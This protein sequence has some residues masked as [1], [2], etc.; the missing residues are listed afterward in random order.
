MA[1]TLERHV[2]HVG[3][4][5]GMQNHDH[6][7]IH[8]LSKS[9]DLLWRCDQYIANAEGHQ[10]LIDFWRTVKKQQRDNIDRMRAL[11]RAEIKKDCF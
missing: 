11:I 7:I 4:T 8:E 5:A 3:E 2:E 1:A 6:D 10:E 9:L